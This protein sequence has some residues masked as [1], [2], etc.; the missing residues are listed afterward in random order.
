MNPKTKPASSASHAPLSPMK[1]QTPDAEFMVDFQDLFVLAMDQAIGIET[2]SLAAVVR[3]N[4]CATDSSMYA[5]WFAPAFGSLFNTA[6]QAFASC[7]ELQLRLMSLMASHVSDTVETLTGLQVQVTAEV[8]ER[9][10]DI[11]IGE[12]FALPSSMGSNSG[13][14]AQTIAEVPESYTEEAMAVGAA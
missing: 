7:M 8:L 1:D 5:V 4:S 6:A 13:G 3:L 11:A 9:S 10:M 14:Q 2:A 12:R